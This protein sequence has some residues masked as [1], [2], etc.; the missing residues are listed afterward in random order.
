MN[1]K[2][3]GTCNDKQ[4]RD[5]NMSYEKQKTTSSNIDNKVLKSGIWY[6]ISNFM[7]QGLNILTLPIFTRMLSKEQFGEFSNYSSWQNILLI[8]VTLNLE[9]TLISAKY[10][11][12]DFDKYVF[13]V[14]SLSTLSTIFWIFMV[15]IF[16]SYFIKLFNM[17]LV[18]INILLVYLLFYPAIS[19]YQA[20][21]RYLFDYWGSIIVSTLLSLCTASISIML[22]LMSDNRLT[23]RV[24]GNMVPTVIIGLVLYVFLFLKGKK[25]ILKMWRYALPIALPFIPHLL[26]LTVLSSTDRIMITKMCNSQATALYSLAYNCGALVTILLSSLNGAFAP[27]LGLKLNTKDYVS[28]K[29]VTPLYV[30]SFCLLAFG[31]MLFAP[32][33]LLILGGENYMV[34]KYVM[35]PVALAC[36]FQFLYTMYVNIEQINKH[37]LEMAIASISAAG[38]NFLLNI[39]LIPIWGY[40]AAAYTTVLSYFWLLIIHMF[41]VHKMKFGFVYD[42]KFILMVAATMSLCT[43]FVTFLYTKLAL[44]LGVIICY[45]LLLITIL[46]KYRK[47][48]I[49]KLI[50]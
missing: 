30:I 35:P 43:I 50:K 12:K 21:A 48:I 4:V 2:N 33:I 40:I 5:K 29:R 28:I 31:V 7:M 16:Q 23:G 26:S 34:A 3:K 42:S 11:F 38:L 49:G 39:W 44:R 20:R 47:L 13:S 8:I 27:W 41:V 32:E 46:F 45:L 9:S 6:T 1:N 15:N 25:I 36:I 37:T 18:Y 24:L 19:L 10:D 17:S 14:L 22:V